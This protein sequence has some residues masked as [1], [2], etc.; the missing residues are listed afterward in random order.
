MK[1]GADKAAKDHCGLS[2][3]H[4]KVVLIVPGGAVIYCNFWLLNIGVSYHFRLVFRTLGPV[5]N[6]RERT[7]L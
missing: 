5:P 6:L 4:F 7:M 1:K 2:Q 3:P